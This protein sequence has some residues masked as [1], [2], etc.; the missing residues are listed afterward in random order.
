MFKFEGGL[1]LVCG[2]VMV[3]YAIKTDWDD[4]PYQDA[5]GK[6][7]NE[8]KMYNV[9]FEW[10]KNPI[11]MARTLTIALESLMEVMNK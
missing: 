3:L 8:G 6:W 1:D 2:E 4:L 7:H 9:A 10:H 11:E 5:D